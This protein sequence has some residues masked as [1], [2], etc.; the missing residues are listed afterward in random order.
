M[1]EKERLFYVIPLGYVFEPDEDK[2]RFLFWSNQFIFYEKAYERME[3]IEF[4]KY[5]ND[6]K[7]YEE[8]ED[9]W[10]E[11]FGIDWMDGFTEEEFNEWKRDYKQ[12]NYDGMW[13]NI[14]DVK[15]DEIGEMTD[16][17]VMIEDCFYRIEPLEEVKLVSNDD[18]IAF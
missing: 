16:N 4:R 10:Q 14:E 8:D 11:C 13:R 2:E 1:N 18:E 17:W 3:T 12:I 9:D 15:I 5:S 7:V 6:E